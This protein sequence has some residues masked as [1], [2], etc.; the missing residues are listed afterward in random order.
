M[1]RVWPL[2]ACTAVTL[3][4]ATAA[5]DA[6]VTLPA[7]TPVPPACAIRNGANAANRQTV[8]APRT[9]PSQSPK[10]FLSILHLP[11]FPYQL[12]LPP[13]RAGDTIDKERVK[14]LL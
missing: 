12:Y 5:P 10:G 3:T 9:L 4:L 13:V 11:A 6:S 1:V 7:N 14:I 2:S 8:T